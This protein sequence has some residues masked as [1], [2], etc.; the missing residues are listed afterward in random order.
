MTTLDDYQR[1]QAAVDAAL[2]LLRVTA[3]Q[4]GMTDATPDQQA[5]VREWA[6]GR[7]AQAVT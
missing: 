6:V 7:L 1:E 2:R 4:P 3:K 5:Q